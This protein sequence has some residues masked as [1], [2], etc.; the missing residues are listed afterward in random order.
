[1]R[2]KLEIAW[3]NGKGMFWFALIFGAMWSTAWSI[4]DR[5]L[6]LLPLAYLM[7]FPLI[8]MGIIMIITKE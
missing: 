2:R 7:P 5:V 1:M 8:Y 4:Q 6:N 3:L